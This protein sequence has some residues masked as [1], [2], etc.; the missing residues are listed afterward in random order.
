MKH[1]LPG[2]WVTI[3]VN[4]EKLR[5]YDEGAIFTIERG[6]PEPLFGVFCHEKDLW[7]FF[8]EK[9]LEFHSAF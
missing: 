3:N 1:L 7:E 9:Q 6:L 5:K 8:E 2:N 4:G